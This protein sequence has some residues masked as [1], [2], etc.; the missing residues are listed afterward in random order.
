MIIERSNN[1][2]LIRMP[3]NVDLMD[4][5][6]MLNLLKYKELTSNSVATQ[7]DAD[8]LANL[9]NQSM[10]EKFKKNRALK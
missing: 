8:E 3:L 1:E 5:E 4:L 7:D 9:A 2:I 6:N 10:I